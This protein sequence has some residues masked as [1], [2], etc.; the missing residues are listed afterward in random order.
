MAK[1]E[2]RDISVTVKL[3]K[4]DL[5]L[6]DKAAKVLWGDAVVTRS[7]IILALIRRAAKAALGQKPA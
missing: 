1:G 2:K 5:E 3:T 6:L 4:G 7:G